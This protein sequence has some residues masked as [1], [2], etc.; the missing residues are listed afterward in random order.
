[1]QWDYSSAM[2]DSASED[3][4]LLGQLRQFQQELNAANT[5]SGDD[6]TAWVVGLL[7]GAGSNTDLKNLDQCALGQLIASN[8]RE[9]RLAGL[10]LIGRTKELLRAFELQLQNLVEFD[11]ETQVRCIAL[12]KLGR[13]YESS[14]D[15]RMGTYFASLIQC[16]SIPE[17]VKYSAYFALHLLHTGEP[18]GPR[19]HGSE[20]LVIGANHEIIALYHNRSMREIPNETTSNSGGCETGNSA[21][22]PGEGSRDTQ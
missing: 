9:R 3:A 15:K 6:F 19:R 8:V 1:M 21:R 7:L 20:T 13:L 16:K 12:Q 17:T 4:Q 2:T 22:K 10:F 5:S 11:D 18:P 14:R